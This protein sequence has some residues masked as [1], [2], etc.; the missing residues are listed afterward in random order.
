MRRLLLAVSILALGCDE[1]EP[2]V[3]P[4][5]SSGPRIERPAPAPEVVSPA[6]R[7][8]QTAEEAAAERE[9][10]GIGGGGGSRS[11]GGGGGGGGAGA[12]PEPEPFPEPHVAD[13][14]N[15]RQLREFQEELLAQI[16]DQV[17]ESDDPCM[18]LWQTQRAAADAAERTLTRGERETRGRREMRE[19]CGEMPRA[20]L[21]CMD[22][23]YFRA[24]VDECQAE[25]QRM[26][27]RG[28]RVQER[29]EAQLE[30]IERGD[31]P[32]PGEPDRPEEEDPDAPLP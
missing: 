30:A 29:A 24:H 4:I 20:Y 25:M 3:Q 11:G 14:P 31:A 27:R 18:Q 2:A 13:P 6:T 5:R 8:R 19:A 1:P 28:R 16:R 32:D 26:A 23:A 22:R 10:L 12:L 7:V 9:R 17:D 21:Q 15:A